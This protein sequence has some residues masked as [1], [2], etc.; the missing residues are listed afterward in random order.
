MTAPRPSH[1][2]LAGGGL[3]LAT[4]AAYS[5]TFAVPFVFDD[6]SSILANPSLDHFGSAWSPPPLLTVSGRPL[7]NVTLALNRA[8]SG[9]SPWSY[10]ALNLLIHLGA[11]L[12]LFGVLRRLLL[13]P[14]LAARFGAAAWPA[15]ATVAA[16]WL[17]HP[18]QTESVTYVI[19]RVESLMGL[20]YF[21]TLYAF[22]RATEGET[23]GR[24]AATTS[25]GASRPTSPARRRLGWLAAS[26]VACLAGMASKEV[27]VSAPLLVL[28][29]DRTFV[30]GSFRAAWQRRTRYYV[31]LAATWLLLAG[32]IFGTRSR[33]GTAGFDTDLSPWT[34][35][36]TQLHALTVYLKL[37]FWPH[38]LVFDYGTDVVKYAA[39]VTLPGFLVAALV[40]GTGWALWRRP[41]LGFAGAWFFAILAPSSSV[42]PVATQTMAE[43][44]MYLPL[45]AVLAAL[46]LG[47]YARLGRSVVVGGLVLAAIFAG[48]T[49]QRNQIY[50]DELALWTDTV[51]R[52]PGNARAHYNLAETLA[53]AQRVDEA[54][55]QYQAALERDP[56]YPE[57][58]NNLGVLLRQTNRPADALACFERASRIDPGDPISRYNYADALA[59][60]GRLDEAV[61]Q[62][63]AALDLRPDHLE[64][65]N[66]FGGVLLA[67]NRPPEAIALFERALRVR[68]GFADAHGNLGLAL[69]QSGRTAE[70]AE[71]FTAVLRTLPRDA[72]A[73]SNLGYL[74][75][76]AGRAAEAVEHY[77]VVAQERP[78]EPE[79]H[80]NL[81]IALLRAGQRMEA[82][83]ALEAALRLRPDYA[84]ARQQ[85][86]ALR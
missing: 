51:A 53:R 40:A 26:V 1:L 15:A 63:R 57:A 49:W 42:I 45:V 33:G 55:A 6:T 68:P 79:S 24:S 73:H 78:T 27:M 48:L 14:P 39:D 84:A 46:I 30:A 11:G 29:A 34:Y 9:V 66:D 61:A 19:Q 25:P 72:S 43:H 77:R 4:V 67:L 35:A 31:A 2:W 83:T 32:L 71:Q 3:A 80:Y 21:F 47:L 28:L 69:L 85:L 59:R 75:L 76:Q 18:L 50:R 86:G 13:R 56:N 38:P 5:H 17:L 58:Y 54:I 12:T 81:A 64:T 52:R 22:L 23:F 74:A 62:F 41:V 65:L 70:A 37:S 7:V 16:L 36:L 8:V 44:R 20:C 82:I 60:A 10:H